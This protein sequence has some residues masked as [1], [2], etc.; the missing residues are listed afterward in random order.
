MRKVRDY[1]HLFE[2]FELHDEDL[3]SLRRGV[4]RV[5]VFEHTADGADEDAQWCDGLGRE[6]AGREVV[7]REERR[8][9]PVALLT[10]LPDNPNVDVSDIIEVL[11]AELCAA[12]AMPTL[13]TTFIVGYART[14]EEIDRGIPETYSV[15]EFSDRELELE[16][17]DGY[18]RLAFGEPSFEHIS[19]E[20]VCA[21]TGCEAG[22]PRLQPRLRSQRSLQPQLHRHE[23]CFMDRYGRGEDV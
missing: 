13:T 15:V 21:V 7:R 14:E 20:T 3:G 5:R 18:I 8:P 4:C 10:E 23:N 11:T 1:I 19:E 16:G 17:V 2:G 22:Q 12:H 9:A 6:G